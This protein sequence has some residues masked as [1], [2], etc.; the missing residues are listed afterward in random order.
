M[1]KIIVTLFIAFLAVFNGNAQEGISMTSIS[2]KSGND[3]HKWQIRVRGILVTP[4]DK[5]SIEGIGGTTDLGLSFMPELDFTYFFTKNFAAELVLATTNH[6]VGVTNTAVGD[7]DLGDVWLLPPTLSFQYHWNV[8]ES[9]RPYIGTGLNYTIFYGEGYGQI[10]DKV[11]YENEFSPVIQFGMDF[12]LNDRWFINLDAKYLFLNTDVEVD[13]S[14][15]LGAVVNADVDI[16]PF[17]AGIGVG[18]KL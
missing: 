14:S 4:D 13:A 6:D 12:D 8:E 16:N 18:V 5:A 2:T 15:R 11:N 9:I 1:K 3:F 17:I 10:A 7:I